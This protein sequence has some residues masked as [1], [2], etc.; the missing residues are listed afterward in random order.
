MN[1]VEKIYIIYIAIVLVA[2]QFY[3]LLVYIWFGLVWCCIHSLHGSLH[4]FHVVFFSIIII[5][6]C[7]FNPHRE[8]R[9]TYTGYFLS[10]SRCAR[11]FFVS[12]AY[13][14]KISLLFL[15]LFVFSILFYFIFC[16]E[17][18]DRAG[19]WTNERT[20]VSSVCVCGCMWVRICSL[21]SLVRLLVRLLVCRF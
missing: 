2:K 11:P 14:P 16:S 7:C 15:V 10:F 9:N 1:L 19:K 12:L 20:S 8:E 21:I 17:T 3:N 5:F 6:D 18:F 13:V 4:L